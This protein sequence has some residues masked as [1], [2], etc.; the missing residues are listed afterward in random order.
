MIDIN[1][2]QD[3]LFQKALKKHQNGEYHDALNLY[4]ELLIN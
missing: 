2:S 1:N 3:I 4:Q